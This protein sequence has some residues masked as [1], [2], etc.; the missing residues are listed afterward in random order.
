MKITNNRLPVKACKILSSF[1]FFLCIFQDSRAVTAVVSRTLFYLPA[2]DGKHAGEAYVEIYWQIQPLSLHYHKNADGTIAAQISTNIVI[3]NEK[4]VAAEEHY[5]VNTTPVAQQAAAAQNIME[6][7]RMKLPYGNYH[8]SFNLSEPGFTGNFKDSSELK[9]AAPS[10]LPLYSGIQLVDT[11][12][13]F[14]DKGH[15]FYK[16][17]QLHIPYCTNFLDDNH[18][19]IKYY[20]ELYQTQLAP[21]DAVPLVQYSFISRKDGE[22]SLKGLKQIDT[23]TP[24]SVMPIYGRFDLSTLSSGNYYL[25]VQL[26]DKNSNQVCATS[27]FFQL[28]NKRPVVEKKVVD[29]TSRSGEIMPVNYLDLNKT[30][31]SKFTLPEMKA[32]LEMIRPVSDPI[33]VK[34]IDGFFKKP[35]E[36]YI[37]YFV[38]N[39]FVKQNATEPEKAWKTFADKIRTINKLFGNGAQ[40]GYRTDR[41]VIYLRYGKPDD[42]ITVNGESGAQPYEIWQYYA[43]GKQNQESFFLFYQSGAGAS[44]NDYIILHSNVAGELHT[45]GWRSY[46]YSNGMS[47][48]NS[49]AEEYIRNR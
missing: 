18:K 44:T 9:V 2:A 14:T 40:P 8:V 42:R 15:P 6:I 23:I 34:A 48:T 16:N 4:G 38:Y 12:V 17:N 1:L 41:G 3:S 24:G 37:R 5:M 30:F 10:E 11:L 20:T 26:Y 21:S 33:D 27:Q 39:Y 47:S 49:R 7:K 13:P 29:T 22:M 28:I 31:I 45:P 32:I 46:L 43:L 19:S 35:D 36:M 25:N